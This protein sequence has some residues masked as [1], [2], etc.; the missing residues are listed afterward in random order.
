MLSLTC[1]STLCILSLWLGAQRGSQL[2]EEQP[3][4]AARVAVARAGDEL[5]QRR[6]QRAGA[7][8]GGS[9]PRGASQMGGS[10]YPMEI[11][12]DVT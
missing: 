5:E 10:R 2:R 8:R 6:R 7:C 4:A 1:C 11:G 9:L 12:H 3:H